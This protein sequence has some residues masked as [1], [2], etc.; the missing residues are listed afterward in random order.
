VRPHAVRRRRFRGGDSPP[1]DR[2][3]D[4]SPD[5]SE[6]PNGACSGRIVTDVVIDLFAA[7]KLL[8][9]QENVWEPP[10]IQRTLALAEDFRRQ[11]DAGGVNQSGL[12]RSHGFTRARVTQVLNLL[13][14]H[15]AVRDY[16]RGLLPGPQSRL[17]TERRVRPLLLLE[18]AAQLD[19]AS[20]LLRGFVPRRTG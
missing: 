17:Y 13:K 1:R 12:A 19:V 2:H 5:G 20:N 6:L 9:Q 14:L 3:E 18:P 7:K 10:P 8:K 11:L 16:L 4:P 15:P